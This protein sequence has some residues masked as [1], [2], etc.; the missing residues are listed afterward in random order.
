MKTLLHLLSFL[1]PSLGW[2]ALSVLLAAATVFSG[3]GLLGTSAYL[4]ASA[5]L[6]PSVAVLQ[7]AIVGVRFF[8]I[9]R[10]LLRY[11]ERLVSH[12]V[13][14]RVLGELRSWFYRTVEPLAPAGLESRQSGDLTARAVGDIETLEDFYVRAV[15]PPV[16]A[17]LVTLG[18]SA[19]VG[20]Y[21]LR[22]G[23]LLAAGLLAAGGLVPLLTYILARQAGRQA[24]AARAALSQGVLDGVQ[25]LADLLVYGR[26]QE[27]ASEVARLS[28]EF[29]LAQQRQA[30]A[31]ALGDALG[32][33]L[34]NLTLW[35]LLTA[36][37][38]LVSA[39][40]L[41]GVSLAV[42][43]LVVLAS[44]EAVTPLSQAAGRLEASLQAGRRLFELAEAAPA[45]VDFANALPAPR[46]PDL[47]VRGLT[48]RYAPHLPPALEDVSFDLPVGRKIALVGPSGAGKSS[49][50]ALLL[51]F[52]DCPPSS[53][54]LDG[55]DIR[56]YRQEDVRGMIGLVTQQSSLFSG[57]LRQ[58]LLLAAPQASNK[59]LEDALDQAQ[60]EKLPSHLPLGWDTWLGAQ[61]AALSGG[62]R[63]RLSLARVFLQ[64]CGLLVLDEPFASLDALSA[65]RFMQTVTQ[66][67]AGR[68]LL[69]ITHLLVGLEEMDDIVVLENGR[70]TERGS[71]AEL[72]ARGG[73]YA[74]AWAVQRQVLVETEPGE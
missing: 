12:S 53:I 50:A 74:R 9:S 54:Q 25:G 48:F 67:A 55:A 28:R 61:G 41:E 36:A 24:V 45:V 35:G 40:R 18:V 64:G 6:H 66:A 14:F 3:I 8:G 42:L 72:L 15:A 70:V 43:S 73:W 1:R 71:Q 58:N 37:V 7:V 13:N 68:S 69:L 46:T 30:A 52:W 39:G 44:F 26:A 19:F 63:Q 10:G 22:L 34:T 60:L 38:P 57:T 56:A 16:T 4:I 47:R 51:R 65:R 21:S 11:L 32:L 29:S 49:L 17:V 20:G 31:G 27:K 23:L 2:V 33:A 5:A 62:E 59:Q